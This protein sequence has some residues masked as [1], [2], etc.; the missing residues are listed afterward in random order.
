MRLRT[1]LPL[2]LLSLCPLLHAQ[3]ATR[4]NKPFDK[5]HFSDG[6]GLK[7]ALAA[8]KRGD[9]FFQSGGTHFTQALGEYEKAHTF[10]PDNAELNLKMGLCHLNG[11]YHH[12]S[13]PYFQAA[14]ELDNQIPRIHFL[15]G[16][17]YHLNA[18]WDEAIAEYQ[19]HRA[20]INRVPDPEP[21]YNTADRRIVECQNGK[22]LQAKPVNG[23]VSNMGPA[24]NSEVAD[25]GVLISPDGSRMTF[26]SR[27]SNST[28]GK[29][30][31][32]TSEYFEDIYGSTRTETGWSA[33]LPLAAPVN[34]E[35]NDASVGLYNDGKTMI[36]YR[37]DKGVGDL[38][39]STREGELWSEPKPLG[40]AINSPANETSAWL[41]ADGKQLFF[42]SDR[43]GGI[44]GQDIWISRWDATANAWGEAENPGPVVNTIE[45]EDGVFLH[46]D[47]QTLYFSSKGH[48][49]MGGYD[50]FK[51][52][53]VD[54]HWSQPENLGWPVNSPDDD[55]FFVLTANGTTGHFSSVRPNG[56]GEDDLYRVDFLPETKPEETAAM[57]GSGKPENSNGANTV[58]LRGKVMDLKMLAG[59]EATIELLDLS[60]GRVVLSFTSDPKTGEYLAVVPGGHNYAMHVQANGYLLHS[61]NISTGTD[62]GT[63]DM[64]M[65]VSLQSMESGTHEVMR[66]IFFESDQATLTPASLGELGQL[67]T[68]LRDNPTL[69]LEIGGHTDSDGSESHNDELST[70]RAYAVVDHLVNNGIPAERLEAKGYGAAQPLVAND[71]E[72]N[73]ARN[74][75]TE[76]RVL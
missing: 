26:T 66:N 29:I 46:P 18:R 61:E 39:E 50:V 19:L 11:R 30:N 42:V 43:E 52:S 74:R 22:S 76:M 64:N 3:S 63:M 57:S 60:D 16:M 21:L 33:P 51:S 9:G 72:E 38:F 65:N 2:A 34:T 70:K 15:L 68:L 62:G 14:Y 6:E 45:D 47:G 37:D 58:T 17:G 25:Y 40:E 27:R 32:A 31:K 49:C 75:R 13:L 59:M 69:R 55:L 4:A 8:L 44:G 28:G 1:L 54:G 73:K 12:R 24:I 48:S 5:D 23:Q 56:L 67:L 71:S 41:S 7:S 10:N 36:I 35:I 20:A 53:L